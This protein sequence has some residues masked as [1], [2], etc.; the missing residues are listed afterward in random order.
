[1]ETISHS[2]FY[3]F[4]RIQPWGYAPNGELPALVRLPR[5]MNANAVDVGEGM[6][7]LL[8]PTYAACASASGR[9]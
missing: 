8:P 9:R 4:D 1:M 6:V 2:V 5:S 3:Y 7:V